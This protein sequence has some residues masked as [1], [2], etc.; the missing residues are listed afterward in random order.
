[1]LGWKILTWSIRGRGGDVN[2]ILGTNNSATSAAGETTGLEL[3]NMAGVFL[4]LILGFVLSI[5]AAV[6]ELL[7]VKLKEPR[8][9]FSSFKRTELLINTTADIHKC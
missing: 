9:R 5:S 8:I 1:M 2:L 4:V 6:V 7:W 3:R